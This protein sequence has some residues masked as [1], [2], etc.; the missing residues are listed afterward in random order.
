MSRSAQ[1]AFPAVRPSLGRC[2]WT[3]ARAALNRRMMSSGGHSGSHSSGGSD[4]PWMVGSALV[5]GPALLY[6]LSPSSRNAS[7][8]HEKHTEEHHSEVKAEEEETKEPPMAD[9]EGTE[10]SGSEVKESMDQAF[11]TDSPKDAQVAEESE[12]APPKDEDAPAPSK[13]ESEVPSSEGAQPEGNTQTTGPDA[14]S[15]PT[16]EQKTE[17]AETSENNPTNIGEA[18]QE[19]IAVSDKTPEKPDAPKESKS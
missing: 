19:A 13:P 4:T 15:P 14:A 2:S 11:N 5:F 3:S 18:R 9:D 7:H 6:L 1:R 8:H 16:E 10:V 17:N 12:S